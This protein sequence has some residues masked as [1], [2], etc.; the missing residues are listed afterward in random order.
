VVKQ[1]SP[2]LRLV[3]DAPDLIARFAQT[4]RYARAVGAGDFIELDADNG[5]VWIVHT[6]DSSL[7]S[8][9]I[10]DVVDAGEIPTSV[11]A[12]VASSTNWQTEAWSAN[13]FMWQGQI[14]SKER[15][16]GGQARATEE[17]LI[18]EMSSPD[19]IQAEFNVR[20]SLLE[21]TAETAD[22]QESN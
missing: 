14:S 9:E 18:G 21:E 1:R 17:G 4:A 12:A 11:R 7:C 10:T 16:D 8:I 20:S 22:E 19:G 6:R 3:S 5:S 13:D 15:T 2:G